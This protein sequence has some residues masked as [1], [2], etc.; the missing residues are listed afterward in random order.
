MRAG[1]RPALGLAVVGGSV[2][3]PTRLR[4]SSAARATTHDWLLRA[5]RPSPAAV[6]LVELIEERSRTMTNTTITTTKLLLGCSLLW[7]APGCRDQPAP[8]TKTNPSELAASADQPEPEHYLIRFACQGFE[9]AVAEGAPNTRML[10]TTAKHAV[11]LGGEPVE[12]ATLR[13]A[14]LPPEGL[15]ELIDRYE[16]DTEADPAGCQPFRAHL[17]RV[18]ERDSRR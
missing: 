16:H 15:L 12:Q 2:K 13:W 4:G 17:E 6:E 9:R 14:L 18:A 10:S 7:L 5:A 8:P 11:E 1:S 3:I